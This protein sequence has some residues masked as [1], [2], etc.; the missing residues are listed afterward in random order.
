MQAS[1]LYPH[2]NNNDRSICNAKLIFGNAPGGRECNWR[3][4]QS[5]MRM[6]RER[7][8]TDIRR[9]ERSGE[10]IGERRPREDRKRRLCYIIAREVHETLSN[11]WQTVDRGRFFI[12]GP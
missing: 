10:K 5:E 1:F 7:T 6:N 9:C 2:L 11:R 12:L 4:K 3:L 8:V